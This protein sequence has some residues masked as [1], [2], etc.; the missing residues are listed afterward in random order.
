[1]V[2]RMFFDRNFK[3]LFILSIL[4]ISHFN[5]VLLAY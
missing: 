1:M 3:I 2:F 5:V 4:Y